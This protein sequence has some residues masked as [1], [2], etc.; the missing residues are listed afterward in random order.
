MT[1]RSAKV[2]YATEIIKGIKITTILMM[3]QISASRVSTEYQ[4]FF[5]ILIKPNASPN[6]AVSA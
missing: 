5:S 4:T 3:I 6:V 1:L 2:K